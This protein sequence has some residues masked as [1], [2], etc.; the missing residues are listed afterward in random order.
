MSAPSASGLFRATGKTSRPVAVRGLDGEI[1]RAPALE[2]EKDDFYRTPPEPPRALLAAELPR[3]RDFPLIW[4]MAAGDG[5]ILRELNAVGLATVASDLVDRGCG[6]QIRSFYDFR[7]APAR[8]GLTNPPFQECDWKNGRGRWIEHALDTLDLDYLALL[9][10]W[11]WPAAAGLGPLLARLSDALAD[12]LDGAG[13]PAGGEWLVRLGQGARRRPALPLPRPSGRAAGLAVR[14]GGL[15]PAI[16]DGAWGAFRDCGGLA[17]TRARA[18]ARQGRLS[19]A[20]PRFAAPP[21]F[22]TSFGGG[23]LAVDVVDAIAAARG[24]SLGALMRPMTDRDRLGRDEAV[25]WILGL[26]SADAQALARWFGARAAADAENAMRR[27][28]ERARLPLLD[29]GDFA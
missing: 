1:I 23:A 27:H 14:R 3:L 20:R 2:R 17:E 29:L 19:P 15:M 5:A 4:E 26:T 18:L 10:P 11:T 25:Y 8:A 6:A 7:D 24:V 28:A 12:R 21:D 22:A 13:R 16:A 9:L